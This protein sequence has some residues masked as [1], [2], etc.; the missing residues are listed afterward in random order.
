[1]VCQFILCEQSRVRR[2]YV[3]FSKIQKAG[4]SSQMA[5]TTGR[6]AWRAASM[7]T[8][9]VVLMF[10]VVRMRARGHQSKCSKLEEWKP[11]TKLATCFNSVG[12]H[13]NGM[14]RC[15]S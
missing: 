14:L 4:H 10:P 8:L 15:Q 11:L 12:M 9:V 1:M 6:D 13:M 5:F 2:Q 3:T 7:D